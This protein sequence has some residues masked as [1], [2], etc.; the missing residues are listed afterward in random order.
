M[1]EYIVFD[2]ETTGFSP[3]A[4]E[5]IEI[6][7]WHVKDYVAVEKFTSCVKPRGYVPLE[8]QHLTGITMEELDSAEPLEVVLPEFYEF[9]GDL[10]FLGY[11]LPFDYNMVVYKG[12]NLG[13]D[14]SLGGSRTGIDAMAVVK[15]NLKLPKNGLGDVVRYFEIPLQGDGNF[16][17][18]LFDAYMTKLVYERLLFDNRVKNKVIPHPLTKSDI[19]YG[20]AANYGT[21]SYD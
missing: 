12:N 3:Q 19:V 20:K 11:N 13:Y 17:R 18:A 14:F 21:L 4:S 16:H 9:C 1:N 8:I 15:S 2:L 10:S 6:G 7:A 5:I